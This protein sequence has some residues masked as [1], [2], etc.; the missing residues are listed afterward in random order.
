M[1]IL[2]NSAGGLSS[3]SSLSF[4]E[5]R[6]DNAWRISLC[7]MINIFVDSIAAFFGGYSKKND[8]F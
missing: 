2:K 5:K 8:F 3:F 1:A 7:S 4:A 6:C